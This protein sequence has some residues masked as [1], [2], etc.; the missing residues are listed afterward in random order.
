METPNS[1]WH[2]RSPFQDIELYKLAARAVVLM[3]NW[4]SWDVQMAHPKARLETITG[5]PLLLAGVGKMTEHGD[6]TRVLLTE[7]HA[8]AGVKTLVIN[9]SAGLENVLAT[10]RRFSVYPALVGTGALCR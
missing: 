6:Q 1:F 9:V 10:A 4:W 3:Y 2:F 8:A 7:T 5:R